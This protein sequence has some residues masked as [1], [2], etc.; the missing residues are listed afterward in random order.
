MGPSW[1]T[2]SSGAARRAS[3]SPTPRTA[4]CDATSAS[5]LATEGSTR[6]IVVTTMNGAACRARRPRRLKAA[7]HAPSASA[8][9]ANASAVAIKSGRKAETAGSG[10]ACP[11]TALLRAATSVAPS[12]DFMR[13]APAVVARSPQARASAPNRS[14]WAAARPR[15]PCSSQPRAAN[16][17]IAKYTGSP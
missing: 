5:A 6:S 13:C 11:A 3:S 8:P 2:R 1:T 4:R 15:P 14:A 17:A 10:A 16:N 12:T 9:A 7:A